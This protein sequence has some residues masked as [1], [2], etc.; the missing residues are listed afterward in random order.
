MSSGGQ[1]IAQPAGA[2]EALQSLDK[3]LTDSLWKHHREVSYT[4]THTNAHRFLQGSQSSTVGGEF[5]GGKSGTGEL[6]N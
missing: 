3:Q 4:F 2:E 5:Q 1:G 6:Q